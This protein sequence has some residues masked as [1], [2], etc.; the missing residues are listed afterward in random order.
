MIL[1]ILTTV[2]TLKLVNI[3]MTYL[4]SVGAING[5]VSRPFIFGAYAGEYICYFDGF[6]SL[7]Q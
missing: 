7:F 4:R 1:N 6:I 2:G 3:P 5:M